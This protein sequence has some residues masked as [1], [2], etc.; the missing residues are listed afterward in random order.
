M[1][2]PFPVF[3]IHTVD[4][5]RE[6]KPGIAQI[7]RIKEDLPLKFGKLTGDGGMDM[8]DPE[9]D[10]GVVGVDFPFGRIRRGSQEKYEYQDSEYMCDFHKMSP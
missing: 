1:I 9:P 8:P 7:L 3:G 6:I 2:V 5:D 4:V 10:L